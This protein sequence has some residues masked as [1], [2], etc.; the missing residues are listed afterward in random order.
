MASCANASDSTKPSLERKRARRHPL[1]ERRENE[2]DRRR[3]LFLNRV[4]EAGE[5]KRWQIRGDQILRKD[6][7][8][9][10]KQWEE[11]LARNAPEG[12]VAPEEDESEAHGDDRGSNEAEMVD[13]VL[14]QENQELEALL[15]LMNQENRA[16]DEQEHAMSDFGSD[17]DEYDS[18]FLDALAEVEGNANRTQP[19][20]TPPADEALDS[21]M[22][23]SMG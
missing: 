14:S 6:F 1:L 11:E 12:P 22:D 20:S 16:K 19:T 2:A 18:I 10:K 13:D 4:K 21:Q 7:I 5:D 8:S 17:V 23:T 15:S 9:Q 3:H